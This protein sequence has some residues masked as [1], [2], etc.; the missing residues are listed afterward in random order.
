MPKLFRL[1]LLCGLMNAISIA[2]A[3][4]PPAPSTQ[5]SPAQTP[6]TTQASSTTAPASQPVAPVIVTIRALIDGRSQL[7][8]KGFTARW[9]HY[10]WAAPGVHGGQREPTFIDGIA[11]HPNWDNS[12]MDAEVRVPHSLSDKFDGLT[13]PI[14]A[15]PTTVTLQKIRGRE[16]MS[17]VQEPAPENEFATI[18]EFN[19]N[20][21]GGY[22]WY[23]ANLTFT[24]KP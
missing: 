7:Q 10:D 23:E 6:P 24:P 19:D 22:D 18:I 2:A 16:N 4:A 9:Q 3:Q 8:L 17:I 5:A 13:P 1:T 11:W 21:N 15:A 14:P 20:S 12:D